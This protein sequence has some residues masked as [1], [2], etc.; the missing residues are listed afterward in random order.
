MTADGFEALIDWNMGTVLVKL[1][2]L[3]DG[4]EGDRRARLRDALVKLE[5]GRADIAAA[6]S[7][8]AGGGPAYHSTHA[9]L[10]EERAR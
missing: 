10:W 8:T 3:I 2:N 1:R 6:L 9:D 7:E 5:A 4:T